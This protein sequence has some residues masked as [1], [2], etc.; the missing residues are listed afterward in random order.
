[1]LSDDLGACEQFAYPPAERHNA[2]RRK[3]EWLATASTE[4]ECVVEM[5]RCLRAASAGSFVRPVARERLV[6]LFGQ[7]RV[8]RS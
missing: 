5:E 3:D 8:R 4:A 7:R 2:G 1:M 6:P